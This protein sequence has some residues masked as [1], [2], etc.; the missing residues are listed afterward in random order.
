MRRRAEEVASPLVTLPRFAVPFL[1]GVRRIGEDHVEGL[2][3]VAFDQSRLMEG[4][5]AADVE[6]GHAV[7]HEVHAGDGRGDVDEFLAVE[8][9]G[10]GVA[11]AAFYLGQT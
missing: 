5:A 7:Q 8:A 10:A 4:V 3:P 1:D 11:A 9:D 6:V 2:E